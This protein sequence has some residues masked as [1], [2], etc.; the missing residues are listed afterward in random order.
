MSNKKQSRH[1]ETPSPAAARGFTLIELMIVL[2]IIAIILALALPVY[3]NYS[4]RAK[5]AEG[6]SVANSAKT[7]VASTCIEAPNIVGLTNDKAGYGFSAGSTDRD[8][9]ADIQVT[10]PCTAPVITVTTKHTGQSPDPEVL[11]TGNL[12]PD[13]GVMSWTCSSSN[14]PPYLLP[15]TCRN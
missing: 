7:G 4:I 5:I 2:S 10:G 15:K 11:L 6:L 3:S 8:Y 1:P 12:A 13:S 9:V 14:T